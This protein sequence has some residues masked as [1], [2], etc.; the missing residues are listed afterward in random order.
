M[1]GISGSANTHTHTHTHFL[2][3]ISE[4]PVTKLMAVSYLAAHMR[5]TA[6][7]NPAPQC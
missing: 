5:K 7:H 6:I 4:P 1:G 2:I 3:G